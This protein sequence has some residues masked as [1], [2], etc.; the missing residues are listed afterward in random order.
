ML[1]FSKISY[2]QGCCAGGSGSPI[3]GGVSAGVLQEKQIE[4]ASNYQYIQGNKFFSRD[5]DTIPLL[6]NYYTRYLYSKIAYG[7]TKDFT[8]SIESGYFFKKLQYG[9]EHRD[10]IS[11]SGIADLIIFPRYDILN[12]TRESGR[13]EITFGLGYKI[14]LGKHNDSMLVFTNP[15]TGKQI[16]TTAPPLVQPTTGAHDFIFYSFFFHGFTAHNFRVFANTLYIKKGWNSLGEKFGDYFSIGVFA[17]KTFFKHLGLTVQLKGEHI[18]PMKGAKN[19]D[20]LAYYNIDIRSTGSKKILFA[21]Q[22]SYSFKSFTIFGLSE[23][24]LYQYVNGAQVVIHQFTA[25]ISYRFFTTSS[26]V[27]DDAIDVYI[28]PMNCKGSA[29]SKPGKCRECGMDLIKR[30]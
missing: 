6:D 16:F 10:T 17:S 22:V 24:P 28:C 20:L 12:R 19:I 27:P 3:A 2:A 7:I 5:H 18:A 9:L 14:P 1:L 4:V 21:P 29:S 15:I 26:K 25:G 8:L 13:T 11:S 30:K 23:I